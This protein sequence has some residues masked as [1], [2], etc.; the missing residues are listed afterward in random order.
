MD[1]CI[2]VC[3]WT[4][5]DRLMNAALCMCVWIYAC[6]C[7]FHACRCACVHNICMYVC[8][9]VCLYVC[10]CVYVCMYTYIYIYIYYVIHLHIHMCTHAYI[11]TDA[12][13]HLDL[14]CTPTHRHT[15]T[16]IPILPEPPIVYYHPTK[17]S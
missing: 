8:M 12:S 5:G 14:T 2:Y 10:M 4:I 16:Y 11:H 17:P 1:I 13:T 7:V 9:C 15:N 6:M 3:I